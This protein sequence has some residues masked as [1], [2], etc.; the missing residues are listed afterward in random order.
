MHHAHESVAT[1]LESLPDDWRRAKALELRQLIQA[2]AP[3]IEERISY[4]MLGYGLGEE[5][6][7]H[8]N[9]QKNY[10][11]LYVGDTQKVDPDNE[12][13]KGL[14]LGKGCIRIKKSQQVANT[15]LKAFIELAV[16][17]WRAGTDLNC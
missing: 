6:L 11:S 2:H 9:A 4:K 10:V 5:N 1:Y 7:F 15:G 17:K 16:K 13:L 14:S 8:L 3:E 12:L